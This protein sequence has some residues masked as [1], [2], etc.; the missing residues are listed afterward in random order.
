M[1]LK[2]LVLQGYKTFASKSEFFFD[3]GITA[4]VGP[5]GSGKSNI[6]D[7]LRWVLGEQSYSSLRG[8]RTTDMIFAGSEKRARAGMAQAILTLDNSDGWLPIDYTEV[9]IGRRAY[10]SGEN[11]YL[12]NGQKV[13]LKDITDLLATSGLAERTYTIIGQGLIDQALSLRAEE[14]RALFEEAA[15]INHYKIRRA[16]TIRQ[17]EETQH[18][19]QRVHD[20]LAEIQPRLTSLKRQAT[21]ARNYEQ[22]LADLRHLLRIWYGFRWEK[23]KDK[24]RLARET[25]VSTERTWQDSRQQLLVQQENMNDLRQRINRRQQQSADLQSQRDDLRDQLERARREVAIL[26][27]RR[28]SLHRQTADIEQELPLLEQQRAAA[29]ADLELATAELVTAQSSLQ[30][31]QVSLQTFNASFQ[32]QQAAIN[33]WQTAVQA[34]EKS[35][36]AAQN[37]L[38]QSE[39]QL[40]Q[41]RERLQEEQGKR[42]AAESDRESERLHAELADLA[43]QMDK[44]QAAADS[45][46][47]AADELRDKRI[48]QQNQRQDLINHLKQLRRQSRDAGDE[49]N[50]RQKEVA[51][52]ETRVE[53]LDQMRHKETKAPADV[54]V[55][56]RLAQ[57]LTIPQA[58]ETAVSAALQTRLA[59]LL[60]PDP[61]H[62][63]R[64][65]ASK[66]PF[67]AAALADLQPPPS[68]PLPQGDGVIGWAS[69]LVTCQPQARP[70]AQLLLGH[71]LLAQDDRAAY[72]LAQSLGVTA[73]S[74]DGLV[75]HAGGL[76]EVVGRSPQTDILAR[77]AEWRGGKDELGR[78]RDELA[79]RESR[80]AKENGEIQ[81][82]QEQVDALQNE[83]RRL[84]RLENEA[85]QR[86]AQ[87]QRNLDRAR[88]QQTYLQRQQETLAR[89]AEAQQQEFAR[90]QERIVQAEAGLA[91]LRDEVVGEE[92]A[93]THARQQLDALPVAEASQQRISLRQSIAAA[94]TIVAGRTAV[95]DSRSATL[96][97]V[98]TQIRRLQDRGAAL[99]NQQQQLATADEEATRQR[100]QQRLDDLTAQL[101]PTRRALNEHRQEMRQFEEQMAAIQR[102]T[103][104]LE[105]H[106]TQAQVKLSQE[107]NHIE[108]L[109]ERIKADLGIVALAY[110]EEQTG[111]TPLPI[112]EVVDQLPSVSE[113]PADIEETIHNYRGQMQR[114]GAIN[115]DAPEEY[116]STQERYDF[117]TQQVEDLNQTEKQLREVIAELDE[118]TSKAFAETVQKV[119]DVFGDTFTQLFDGGAA[120]LVLTDPDDLTISGVDIIARLPNRREQ[121]L[122]LLSGGERSLTAA[123]LIFSL[124]KVSPTPFCVMDEVDA[125]LDEANV[126]RFRDLLREL[127]L[128][129]QFVVIT[130]NR[131]TFE[132]ADIAYGITLRPDGASEAVSVDIKELLK[133]GT[134]L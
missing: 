93:V 73:V 45:A 24:L 2:R 54:T 9:E 29:A 32:T 53:M 114:M 100:L 129:T 10:R 28:Q 105:T 61:D 16:T 37:R 92:T 19:L 112:S 115:P 35:H 4:V 6:A 102:R 5:N 60:L 14:R 123:A 42:A 81:G 90:L 78:M 116:E 15:G 55:L 71:I 106:Y 95:V 124:L 98:E 33:K 86:V 70:L 77:E 59:T 18:N 65:L 83:E 110:D 1:K 89:R 49:L 12:L 52:L 47:A 117:L 34:A 91:G 58:Y 126:N 44:L 43:A 134:L 66:A 111:P 132:A 3:D 85:G 108:G 131:G 120:R 41:L 7:A 107:E 57:F 8:K 23:A 87:A 25:A 121:G 40:A 127:S 62:L 101:E 30:S 118:L 68:P 38:A 76:V 133:Q 39:G 17:L 122:G 48:A 80:F 125:A 88:Q 63:W 21:R 69:E 26:H 64:M 75:A 97:Q 128:N 96:K 109:Q 72:R 13:R 82:M 103:M 130:H 79:D 11:E 27:E 50:R 36:R 56:G 67:S 84:G 31:E 99:Q 46:Q 119:N 104:E 22:V 20:I 94:Q 113:L 74:L 51:R